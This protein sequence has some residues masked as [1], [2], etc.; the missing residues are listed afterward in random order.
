M[1]A[2]ILSPSCISKNVNIIR[3]PT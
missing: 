3:Q 2:N 1:P